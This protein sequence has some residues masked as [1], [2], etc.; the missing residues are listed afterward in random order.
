MPLPSGWKVFLF[1]R[2]LGWQI[3][4]SARIGFSYVAA[5][6]VVMAERTRIGHLSVFRDIRLRMQNDS[7]IGNWN[8]VSAARAFR[9]LPPQHSSPATLSLGPHSA[10]TSRHYIDASGGITIGAFTTIA[11]VRSTILSHQID[12]DRGVQ[13]I[14]PVRIGNYCF[15]SSNICIVPGAEVDDQVVVAMGAVI[16]GHLEG[17]RSYG[18]VPAKT[19]RTNARSGE[20]FRR[21][22]GVV[23][24]EP[25][26]ESEQ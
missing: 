25:E 24:L 12:L 23:G 18:G 4:R 20:Y 22:R 14:R 26:V 13:S 9:D 21:R 19:I 15:L 5:L 2:L 3:A 16:V 8:W 7:L 1:R 11:G 10:I 6:D 17:G